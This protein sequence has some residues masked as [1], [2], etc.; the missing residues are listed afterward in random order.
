MLRAGPA[1]FPSLPRQQYSSPIGP[2]SGGWPLPH[3]YIDSLR[4]P[5]ELPSLALVS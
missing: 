5:S 3:A 1:L 4:A 2:S